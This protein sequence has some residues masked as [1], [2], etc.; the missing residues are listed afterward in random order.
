MRSFD[1]LLLAA[2]A[3]SPALARQIPAN[4]Q[5]LYNSIRAQGTCKNILKGGFYSQEGDSKNF[6]YCGDHLSDYRIMYLQGTGG[7]LVNMDIDCD[8]AL[9]TGDGSCDSSEDTQG[10]TSFQSTVAGYKKGIKDLNAYIHS[11]VVLGN[12]GSKSGY[13]TFDPRSVNVQPLS[14]VAVVCG[15][16]MFYGVWGDT[17]GDDGPPLVG[18]VSDSLGRACYGNAVNGNAAHDPNDVLYIAF[19]G[20]DAVPGANGANWAAS[21]FSAFESSLGSLGDQLVARIG[22]TGGST[23]PPPASSTKPSGSQPT[24]SWSGHCAGASC[25][26]DDDCSDDLTCNSGK[27]GTSGSTSPPPPPPPSCSWAGH[28]AGASCSSDDDCSDELACIKKVCAVDPN[29]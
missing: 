18:E 1:A 6:S 24:C 10:Q 12:E 8:G 29:N 19:T 3:A 21:S 11:F 26:S 27:C 28:C 22:S 25:G 23:P 2:L 5:S 16:Q 17:N 7:N 4:V 14:I 15:N 9:G 20:N 13:V